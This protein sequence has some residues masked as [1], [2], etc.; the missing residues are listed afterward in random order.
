MKLVHFGPLIDHP[1]L[2]LYR[3]KLARRHRVEKESSKNGCND[4]YKKYTLSVF[5]F[6]GCTLI[7]CTITTNPSPSTY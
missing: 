7:R 1:S 5:A 2:I 3:D 6:R 4:S